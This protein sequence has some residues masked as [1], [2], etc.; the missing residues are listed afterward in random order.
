MKKMHING[1]GS[2][3]IKV[4]KKTFPNPFTPTS[5]DNN[6]DVFSHTNQLE[7]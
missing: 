5:Q 1:D 2:F 4:G 3:N 7:T 6:E